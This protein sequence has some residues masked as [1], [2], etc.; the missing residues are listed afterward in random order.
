MALAFEGSATGTQTVIT[1]TTVVSG[2][3]SPSA[4][5]TLVAH[6]YIRNEQSADPTCEGGGLTW[7]LVAE[8]PTTGVGADGYTAVFVAHAA[9][10]PGSMTVTVTYGTASKAA[11]VVIWYTGGNSTTPSSATGTVRDTSSI[12]IL[13]IDMTTAV[14]NSVVVSGVGAQTVWADADKPANFTYRASADTGGLGAEKATMG[15]AT[16]LLV[17]AGV[18]DHTWSS[19]GFHAANA[20]A[21]VEVVEAAAATGRSQ[22]L[23]TV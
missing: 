4:G 7:T 17:A 22:T 6:C 23:V 16:A 9:S 3:F 20:G 5:A 12:K 14:D 19:V 13:G 10:A 1:N 21:A 8:I 11:L 18:A 2:S 15:V